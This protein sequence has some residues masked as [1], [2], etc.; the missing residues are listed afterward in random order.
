MDSTD[1]NARLMEFD[2]YRL[3]DG[4]I[5]NCDRSATKGRAWIDFQLAGGQMV[6]AKI[7]RRDRDGRCICGGWIV[8]HF[9]ANNRKLSCEQAAQA[10]K[11]AN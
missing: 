1:R 9:D 8:D 11:G 2:E 5:V 3:P 6:V 10:V 7:I 4:R